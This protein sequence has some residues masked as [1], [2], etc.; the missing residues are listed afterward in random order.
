[1]WQFRKDPLSDRWVVCAE[2]RDERPNEYPGNGGRRTS[3]RCPFCAGHEEDT[4]PQIAAYGTE[5]P[6]GAGRTPDW[7]VR[8]VPN[9][10]PAFHP[11]GD[12]AVREGDLYAGA[13]PVGAQE[14]IVESPRH[15]ASLTQLTDEEVTLVLRA[16]RDRMLARRRSGHYRYVL[17]F[18]NV[19]PRAGASLE[20]SHSQLI[21]MPRVPGEVA[22]E[23]AAAQRLY[24]QHQACFFCRVIRDEQTRG[25]RWV[26]ESRRFLATCPY[27]SRMPYEMWI[28]PRAHAAHFEDQDNAELVELAIFL[29]EMIGKLESLHGDL[30][31][32]YFIHTIPFDTGSS[33][34]YHWHIEI[35]PRL[36][37]TAGFEWGAGY[38]INPVP[39]EQAATI[40][41]S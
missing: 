14:V 4:P 29:R 19:G 5:M 3:S 25:H 8:V 24:H 12:P 40:L 21:A 22:R 23:V 33:C 31:Y 32:N 36:T 34:H 17:A 38:T 13:R 35:I 41:R 16:Y 37:T 9:K 30:A 28:L 18:K 26:A 27:A 1:M 2:G 15:V 39:P 6:A 20:H 7:L 10:Y 11:G